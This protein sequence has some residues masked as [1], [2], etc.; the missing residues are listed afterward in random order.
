MRRF[1]QH[2]RHALAVVFESETSQRRR[3][4]VTEALERQQEEALAAQRAE[5]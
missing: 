1:L 5:A 3:R 4:E 2:V